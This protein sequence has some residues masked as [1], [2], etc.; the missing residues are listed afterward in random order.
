MIEQI[1][2]ANQIERMNQESW[3]YLNQNDPDYAKLSVHQGER[4]ILGFTRSVCDIRKILDHKET[5]T[6]EEDK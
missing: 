1:V 5:D 6:L 2:R 3:W 4:N